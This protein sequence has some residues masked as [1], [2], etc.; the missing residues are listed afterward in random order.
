M[1]VDVNYWWVGAL[2][3][4]T[5]LLITWVIKRNQKDEKSF[6]KEIIQSELKTDK[7]RESKDSD[8]TPSA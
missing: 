8:I 2:A 6:E 4:A 7:H 3:I 5:I 1:T